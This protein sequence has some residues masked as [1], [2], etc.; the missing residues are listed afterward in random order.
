MFL[1]AQLMTGKNYRFD[2][3]TSSCFIYLEPLQLQLSEKSSALPILTLKAQNKYK[4]IVPPM[5]A[6]EKHPKML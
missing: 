3:Q 2:A 1:I 6:H 4:L 5:L